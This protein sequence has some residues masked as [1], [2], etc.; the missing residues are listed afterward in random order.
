MRSLLLLAPA[1]LLTLSMASEDRPVKTI[2]HASPETVQLSGPYDSV[3]LI[4]TGSNADGNQVDWTRSAELI[5][6]PHLVQIDD[7]RHVRPLA[8]GQEVLV[9]RQGEVEIE[10]PVEVTG[11]DHSPRVSFVRDVAPA[12]SRLG[13]NAGTCHGSANGQNGFKLSLR[14]YDPLADHLA[15]TSDLAGRRVD[16]VSPRDSLF[17]T[18]STSHVPHEGGQVLD[19][20]SPAHRLLLSWIEQGAALVESDPRPVSLRVVPEEATIPMP[21]MGQQF[22]VLATFSDGTLRDVT[23]QAFLESGDL[24]VLTMDKRGLGTALRRGESPILVRYEGNYAAARLVVMGDRSGWSYEKT[25][26]FNWIDTLVHSKL[27]TLRSQP[28]EVCTDA[29]FLRRVSLDLTGK[30]PEAEAVRVFLMD[31]RPSQT[32]RLEVIDRFLGSTSYVDHWTNRWANLMQVNSKYVGQQGANH[33]RDWIRAQ[34]A[35]NTPYDRFVHELLAAKGT[36]RDQPQS[37]FWRVQRE[38]D[39]AME[40]VTQLFL[41]IRFNCNKCHDHPFERWTQDQHW[42]LASF[43]AQVTRESVPAKDGYEQDEAIGDGQAGEVTHQRT[44][45]TA[46]LS[47]PFEHAG[48]ASED[49]PRRE[50]FATWVATS[51]N[52]YFAR[53][54]TNRL[55]AYLTGTG[56]IEPIDDM[57]AGNP[58]SN[59]ELL[60]R[61]TGEFV[62]SGFD[63]RHMLRLICQSRTY[64]LST[65]TNQWNVDDNSNYS[66]AK[67]R[68]L[69]A[70]VLFDA[71]YQAT[72]AQPTFTGQR[73]GTLAAQLVDSTT[74]TSDGFLD[75][76]GRPPRES[77]CECERSDSIS[78]GQA[79]NLVNG[80][81]IGVAVE[82][83]GNAIE[84]LIKY[85]PSNEKVLEELYL[86]FLGRPPGENELAQLLPSLDPMRRANRHALPPN[87]V[88]A[89][90][91]GQSAWE[92]KR[93][94]QPWTTQPPVATRSEGEA[95]V[96]VADDGSFKV[97]GDSPDVD[98]TTLTLEVEGTG[99]TGLRLEALP[100]EGLAGGGP[101]RADNGNFVLGEIEVVAIPRS[102]PLAA[103]RV[104]LKTATADFSQVGWPVAHAI[105]GN[106]A[107]G[108]AVMPEFG[109]RHVAIFEAA[110]DFGQEGGIQLVV[111]LVQQHGT[112]HTLGHGRLS[113]TRGPR[114]VR[115]LGLTQATETA[116][117]TDPNDRSE[118]QL[119]LLHRAY[120]KA[121]PAMA[122]QIRLASA[123]DL[124]WAL[125]NS[126]SFL[127][128]R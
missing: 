122:K 49:A 92:T 78:L 108:W 42:Q 40:S 103:R 8:E 52:L 77:I 17:L 121:T 26:I 38:P 57:R 58:P 76:F 30:I 43:L 104:T 90:A 114:P 95:T 91:A 41:G 81:T 101:G 89:F 66:H 79:L 18:K 28:G 67:A 109:K 113:V 15:L 21:G 53:N 118:E 98:R 37:A 97:T 6:E 123:R 106:P 69:P 124:A 107:T 19:P 116:L 50:R 29:E 88:E 44:G 127:F 5:S 86:R 100:L 105:D 125:A 24:E 32:K 25:P 99:F 73:P 126:P 20:E 10:V 70:E 84:A 115:H 64:Q 96:E 71:V 120:M 23:A 46:A 128:N 85:E 117:R 3:Q 80:P 63:V 12:L 27:R 35:S 48:M 87:A 45:Q 83:Q 4:L 54:Y 102:N 36:T 1:L 11:L 16:R 34:V 22:A 60:K 31:S 61:L 110:E 51:E 74:K 72:G 75:L 39:L 9:F 56:L 82:A 59:P 47:F 65:R 7:R 68:R 119:D 2:F 111:T 14:G 62:D 112:R 33:W 94:R 93:R 13:C 55:W